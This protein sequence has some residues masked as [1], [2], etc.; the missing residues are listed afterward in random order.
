MGS[1]RRTVQRSTA[2]PKDSSSNLPDQSPRTKLAGDRLDPQVG[3]AEDAR[4]L[5]L[6]CCGP[7]EGLDDDRY[8]L[9]WFGGATSPAPAK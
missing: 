3:P 2:P 1:R 6:H 7:A 8:R 5:W 9:G 4:P